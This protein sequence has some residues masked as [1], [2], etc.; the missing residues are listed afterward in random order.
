MKNIFI[1]LPL[2]ALLAACAVSPAQKALKEVNKNQAKVA[3]LTAAKIKTTA[4]LA[5]ANKELK[6]S[7]KKFDEIYYKDAH[8]SIEE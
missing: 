6:E 3:V 1:I 2:V 8:P 4:K 5:E 7:V